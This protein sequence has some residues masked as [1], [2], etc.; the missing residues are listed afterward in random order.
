VFIAGGAW[1][2]T[3]YPTLSVGS[4][5]VQTPVIVGLIGGSLLV[6]S[7]ISQ[8]RA[9]ETRESIRWALFAGGIPL[10]LT[11][12]A[13]LDVVG[14]LAILLSLVLALKIDH[15]LFGTTSQ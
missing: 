2:V 8:Y 12:R 3:Q 6:P 15:R 7:I 5:T 4:A 1:I 9:G 13:P 10:S 11:Q 14:V